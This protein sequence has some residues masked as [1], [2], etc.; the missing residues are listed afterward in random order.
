MQVSKNYVAEHLQLLE[1]FFDRRWSL[2]GLKTRSFMGSVWSTIIQ[3]WLNNATAVIFFLK[4]FNP[5]KLYPLS[6][7]IL[8]KRFVS[9]FLFIHK[10]LI[11]YRSS[12]INLIAVRTVLLTFSLHCC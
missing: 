3:T 11:K 6:R 1:L 7:Y 9:F 10:H 12:T 5:L 8:I 2:G 4:S